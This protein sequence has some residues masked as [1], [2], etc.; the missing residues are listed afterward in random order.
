[1]KL[2]SDREILQ[3]APYHQLLASKTAGAERV[4]EVSSSQKRETSTKEIRKTH[5]DEKSKGD[6]LIKQEEREVGGIGLKP[7]MQYLNQNK[8]YLLFSAASICHL[9]FVIGSILQNSWMAANVENP[10]VTTLRLIVV[11]LVIGFT[12]TLILYFRSLSIVALG[13]QSPKSLFSQLP[14]SLF[15]MPMS[16]YDST[17]LGRILS[18]V[19]ADLSIVDLD[20]PFSFV[21]SFSSTINTYQVLF[22]SIPMI[23]LAILLQKSAPKTMSQAN[24]RGN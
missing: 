23:Y 11:Y 21:Y 10:N 12:S 20:V 9:A 22:I 18:R 16:F 15:H 17:P 8:G 19:S 13:M 2:M 6:Q 1:M 3:A 4:E 24:E 5:T 14:N 7:Y